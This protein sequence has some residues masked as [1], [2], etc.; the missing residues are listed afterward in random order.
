MLLMPPMLLMLSMSWM[1][2]W[3]RVVILVM[4]SDALKERVSEC[5]GCHGLLASGARQ[6]YTFEK[7]FVRENHNFQMDK[8]HTTIG[9]GKLG[10]PSA[11][12]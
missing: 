6:Q 8:A 3:L 1:N 5:R 7:R 11:L 10:I 9:T 4:D 2:G 12:P